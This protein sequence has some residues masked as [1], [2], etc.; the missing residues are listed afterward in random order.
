MNSPAGFL[1]D[2]LESASEAVAG[3]GFTVTPDQ[4]QAAANEVEEQTLVARTGG[5]PTLAVGMSQIF[6]SAFGGA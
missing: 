6:S 3:L 4:L 1:G 2:S 5:A